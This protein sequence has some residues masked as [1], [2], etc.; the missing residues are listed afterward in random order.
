[1]KINKINTRLLNVR[2]K[3]P[4]RVLLLTV[5]EWVSRQRTI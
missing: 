1:M 4:K 3:N 2:E 5:V